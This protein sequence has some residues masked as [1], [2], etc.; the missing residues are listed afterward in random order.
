MTVVKELADPAAH[1]L[2]RPQDCFPVWKLLVDG[3]AQARKLISVKW[4]AVLLL[5]SH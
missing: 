1:A 3:R 2:L 4:T 5:E